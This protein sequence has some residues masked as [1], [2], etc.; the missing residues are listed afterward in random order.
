M[1]IADLSLI[2]TGGVLCALVAVKSEARSVDMWST[3]DGMVTSTAHTL[4][5]KSWN[6]LA[7][8][9]YVTHVGKKIER[10]EPNENH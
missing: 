4:M 5:R 9:A 10:G 2:E 1:K 3:T 6:V 7:M 8:S